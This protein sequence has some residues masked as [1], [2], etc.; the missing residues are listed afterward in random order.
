MQ[1][2]DSITVFLHFN[3]KMARFPFRWHAAFHSRDKY[4]LK[5]VMKKSRKGYQGNLL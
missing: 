2:R 5:L 1:N 3:Q 4:V